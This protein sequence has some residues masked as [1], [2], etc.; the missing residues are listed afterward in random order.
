[1]G[2][3][4]MPKNLPAHIYRGNDD[5]LTGLPFTSFCVKSG[6]VAPIA[7]NFN[8]SIDVLTAYRLQ[9]FS[10][11]QKADYIKAQPRQHPASW[12]LTLESASKLI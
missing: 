8:A 3:T 6:A 12:P 1:M 9:S 7:V 10:D 2:H 4:T 5:K 11:R